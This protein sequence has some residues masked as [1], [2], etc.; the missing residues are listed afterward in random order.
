MYE[1]LTFVLNVPD[2]SHV[3]TSP[4][5]VLF[6]HGLE[7]GPEGGKVRTM[8]SAGFEVHAP[9]LQSVLTKPVRLVKLLI[10]IQGV[11]ILLTLGLMC[12]GWSWFHVLC[13][14]LSTSA[15]NLFL[16]DLLLH[17]M[18]LVCKRMVLAD[19]A[20]FQPD[21]LVGSSWGGA[22]LTFILSDGSWRGPAII[23]ASAHRSLAK[24]SR[25]SSQETRIAVGSH[26][27]PITIVHGRL[28]RVCAP[29]G[30]SDL[31]KQYREAGVPVKL[32][33]FDDQHGLNEIFTAERVAAWIEAMLPERKQIA[34]AAL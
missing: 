24:L 26:T 16:L 17:C 29:I 6:L 25:F 3:S 28:D 31:E 9:N 30:S 27:A 4:I 18:V 32:H 5:R 11:I 10:S 22:I 33:W 19:M 12:G 20:L 23:L 15:A 14:G 1:C 34:R 2:S 7:S 21:V 13:F 8:R